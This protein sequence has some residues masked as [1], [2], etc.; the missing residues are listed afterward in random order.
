[1]T[2]EVGRD[3]PGRRVVYRKR[4]RSGDEESEKPTGRGRI[5]GDKG[6]ARDALI[7]RVLFLE[8]RY[9]NGEDGEDK[10]DRAAL[11][12]GSIGDFP[13]VDT[14]S[15]VASLR[16]DDAGQSPAGLQPS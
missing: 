14:F 9:K 6:T 3:N 4:T 15:L 13:G 2:L 11:G 16:Q 8:E 5:D 1:M 7:N 12:H 10:L